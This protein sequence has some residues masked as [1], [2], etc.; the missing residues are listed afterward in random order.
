MVF[1]IKYVILIILL[2]FVVDFIHVNSKDTCLDNEVN[3]KL[4]NKFIRKFNAKKYIYL[5][6]I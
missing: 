1:L 4:R 6:F 3:S 5:F 2:I